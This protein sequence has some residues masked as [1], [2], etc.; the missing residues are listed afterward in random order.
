MKDQTLFQW[1][2]LYQ[3]GLLDFGIK[4]DKNTY[5]AGEIANGTLHTDADKSVKVRK[6]NVTVS[7]KERYEA[8]MSGEYGHSSE[9]YDIFFF[10][11]LS[12]HLEPTF[13]ISQDDDNKIKIPQ[14]SCAIP[15]YFSIPLNTLESYQ[16]KHAR[17]VYEVEVVADMG[18]WKGDYHH[19]LPFVVINPKMD[20]RIGDKYYLGEEQEK[21]EGQPFL[22][23][24]LEPKDSTEELPKFSPGEIMKGRLKIENIEVARVRK[25]IFEL[26]SIEYAR[27]GLPRTVFDN[28]KKQVTYDQS[29][30]RGILSFEIQLPQN[31][32]RSFNANHSEFYWLL[33]SK[34]DI[35]GSSD[36]YVNKVIQVA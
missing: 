22:N 32:K 11:D 6:L 27:W 35:S 8:G 9:K 3:Y 19:A 28:I 4:L 34:L 10:E 13:S 20:Y 12:S 7:G 24:I 23:V 30:D 33:E 14:G 2:Y 26:H 31:A 25:A 18:R 15:F 21:K 17:I 36:I 1:R 5:E 29:K 16:G